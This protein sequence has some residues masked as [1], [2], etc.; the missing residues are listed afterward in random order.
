MCATPALAVYVSCD[1][2]CKAFGAPLAFVIVWW[3]HQ[4]QRA[5]LVSCSP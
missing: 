5:K 1:V 3:P 2:D 4:V